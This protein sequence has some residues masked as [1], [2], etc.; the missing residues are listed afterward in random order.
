[1][2]ITIKC[3]VHPTEEVER[4]K[5]AIETYL[6]KIPFK[7]VEHNQFI[8]LTSSSEN[9]ET[10][11]IVRQSI[12]EKRILDAVRTRLRKNYNDLDI[13]TNIHIDK[14]AAYVGKFRVIDNDVEN[15]PLGCIEIY[16]AF[17]TNSLFEEFLDWFS[18][19]TKNGKVV[20]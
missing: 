9:R 13:T 18:P 7:V 11:S 16:M 3:P 10:L 4:V 17:E 20:S 1:M 6:G 5:T 19:K 14:Q 12:H 15:P 8:E 2:E